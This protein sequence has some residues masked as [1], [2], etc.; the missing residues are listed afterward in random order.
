MASYADELLADLG[1]DSEGSGRES[2]EPVGD[3]GANAQ[4]PV[5]DAGE[6]KG[7]DMEVD[8]AESQKLM[9]V[10]EGGTRPA[11]EMD[12]Q[13]VD[14]MNLKDV[15]SVRSVAKLLQGSKLQETLRAIDVYINQPGP[16][17]EGANQAMAASSEDSDEYRLIVKSNNLAVDI[18]NE[19]LIVHKYIRDH[20]AP[21][22]PELES[23]IPNP[24]DFVRA[25]QA[26]GND[27]SLTKASLEQILPHGTVVVISMTASTTQGK[28]LSTQ[29]WRRVEEA[30][31]SVFE[32][33][34]ARRK[35]LSYV[36]SRMTL[37]A[38]NLSAVV[39]TRVATKLLGVAGGLTGL[40]KIP[41]CNVHLLGAS[42]KAATGFSTAFH[43]R[44]VGFIFQAPLIQEVGEEY[45]RQA[46]RIVSAKAMLAARVDMNGSDK[47]GT[48]GARIRKELEKRLEKLQEP[49]PV[50]M[51]KA[52]PIPKEG[53]KK[54]QRG[55]RRARKLKE[56]NGTT[57]LKKQQNR[58][59]FGKAE[60]EA[61]IFDETV[62]L[63]MMSAGQT[64]RVRA[65]VANKAHAAKMSKSN[66]DR[67]AALKGRSAA[68]ALDAGGESSGTASSLSFTPV[69]G[70]ELVDPSRQRR[71]DEA[72]AKWFKE[73]TFSLAPGARGNIIPGSSTSGS[74]VPSAPGSMGPPSLP[75]TKRPRVE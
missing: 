11:E 59:E 49:P 21:R 61:G 32:L 63:G 41:A 30:T 38:P 51:T 8:G 52:L 72:N 22:F 28:P 4:A 18:D 10:P 40:S 75:P 73:G 64:G 19:V 56:I 14:R 57:D 44:P 66:K 68:S 23:L 62:G 24:W 29:E 42:K 74:A 15:H 6:G 25:V 48:Y 71:V 36:E 27:E 37:I 58:M 60:D 53:G 20:Y 70:I 43:N 7:E 5:A 1:S 3:N 33:E 39:G 2:P 26:L 16:S 46:Q 9:N 12:Q 67:L 17:A 69:Q 47:Y 34:A 13:E 54:Q 35:I 50:K 65:K 45:H 55:G 31:E